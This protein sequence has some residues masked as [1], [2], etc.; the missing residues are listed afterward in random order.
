MKIA[1]IKETVV[2]S[3]MENEQELELSY[4][5]GGNV[6]GHRSFGKVWMFLKSLKVQ[7][8]YDPAILF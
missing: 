8:L 1:I 3:V 5:A 2:L 7:L 4:T 6:K